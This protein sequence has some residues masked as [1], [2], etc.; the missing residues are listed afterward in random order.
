MN[1]PQ[2]FTI[3]TAV[4][5]QWIRA[6]LSVLMMQRELRPNASMIWLDLEEATECYCMERL[7]T[8]SDTVKRS[9]TLENGQTVVERYNGCCSCTNQ[10]DVIDQINI[11]SM[12]QIN[13]GRLLP[14]YA[15]IS[16]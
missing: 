2:P 8:V 12:K 4:L 10:E 9:D 15:T 6:W 14:A 16:S 5:S 7:I 13:Q 3:V 11:I 1:R